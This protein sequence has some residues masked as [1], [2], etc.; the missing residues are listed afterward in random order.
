VEEQEQVVAAMKM[1]VDG[2]YTFE[3]TRW[4]TPPDIMTPWIEG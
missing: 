3:E 2:P 4:E 1:G